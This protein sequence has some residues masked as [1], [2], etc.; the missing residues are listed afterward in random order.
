MGVA[1]EK[2]LNNYTLSN[3]DGLLYV[4]RS[5]SVLFDM[6][7]VVFIYKITK[8][9][10]TQRTLALLASFLYSISVLP[11]QA[12]HFYAVDISLTFFSTLTLYLLLV[13]YKN[14]S[15]KNTLLLGVSFGLALATKITIVLLVIPI[16]VALFLVYFKTKSVIKILSYILVIF[17]FTFLIF[18]LAMPYALIDFLQFKKQILEQLKMNSDP[19]I[20]PFTLQYVGTT[21]YWYYIKNIAL[22]GLGIPQGVLALI[23]TT[24]LTFLLSKKKLELRNGVFFILLTF[25]WVY[26]LVVG[27]SAVKFM[28]YMLPLYPL[29]AIFSAYAVSKLYSKL[30]FLLFTFYFLLFLVWPFSFIRIYQQTHTRIAAT[31]WINTYIPT[32]STLSSEHWDD[33]IPLSAGEKYL[34][35]EYPL[36]EKDN[37]LKWQTLFG[38]IAKT[39]YIIL[40]SNRLYVPLQKLTDCKKYK[41]CYP[42]TA[43]YYQTL[44]SGELGFV[45]VARFSSYPKIPFTNIEIVDDSADE[46]FTVYDHPLIYIFKNSKHY[47]P[48]MLAQI[49][50]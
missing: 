45:Q 49:I 3:Y 28:R 32:G 36:Y 7:T 43:R 39:D 15:F 25:F 24:S 41:V 31:S 23:S 10:S 50:I 38:K 5:L 4:G 42:T 17:T 2:L 26:F 29:F 9:I 30:Q 18:N 11:I 14:P 47:E 46:S 21:P 12:S 8:K 16:F 34:F 35:I 33:R 44:F 19:Y 13:F 40:A 48:E 1:L 20:F 22:W 37:E 27:K 6:L